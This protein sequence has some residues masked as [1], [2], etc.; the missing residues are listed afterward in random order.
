[1]FRRARGPVLVAMGL[2]GLYLLL[3]HFTGAGSIITATS[4]AAVANIK[5]LQG[6]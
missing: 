2:I 1:M 5:A 4:N 6:R 3:V